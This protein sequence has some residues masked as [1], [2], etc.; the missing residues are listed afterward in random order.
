MS[1]LVIAETTSTGISSG[2]LS[3][4]TAASQLNQ[5]I[6]VLVSGSHCDI[7]SKSAATVSGVSTVLMAKN[8]AYDKMVAENMTN[9][10]LTV[11]KANS[12]T[13][14]L[15]PSSNA[16]KNFMPR[17]GA[18]LDIAP[19]SDITAILDNDTF[20]RPTYA[21]NAMAQVKSLDSVK[22][23][24]IRT[25]GF[26]KANETDGKGMIQE[27][28]DVTE[29]DAKLTT[30]ESEEVSTSDRPD[31]TAATVVI[32]GGR[33]MKNGENFK[34]LET[35]ADKLGG[36]VGASRAAVD[37]GYVPNELQVGQTG[38]V[39]APD[40]YIAVGISGAIQHL[41]GMKDSKTIVC[42]NKDEEAPI[43]QVS[44]YGLVED[45]FKAVPALTE[46]L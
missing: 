13:H 4:I 23:L 37:A 7:A 28:P 43:F 10:I 44:D 41:A 8:A 16:T 11:Q 46:K 21:G 35:L 9:L 45:L 14:I 22:L 33:G 30:F 2:T 29:P 34:L 27:A 24:T 31:L 3:A 39:V 18:M 5:D 40:L 20:E 38:K 1:T 42:I 26:E 17:V 6:T 15:A 32:S 19:L 36:A 12:Y 25:T